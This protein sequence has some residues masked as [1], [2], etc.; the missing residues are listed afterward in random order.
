MHLEYT[1]TQNIHLQ[2]LALNLTKL[3]CTI[4]PAA[5]HYSYMPLAGGFAPGWSF[6][7]K[8]QL[9]GET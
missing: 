9:L 7:R 2:L 8:E 6:W 1:E 4:C 3:C 5:D